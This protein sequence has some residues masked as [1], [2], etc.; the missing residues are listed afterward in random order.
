D[1]EL[2]GAIPSELGNLNNLREL[3]L[4]GN[5]LSGCVPA[6]WRSVEN[7]DLDSLGLPFCGASSATAAAATTDREALISLY[8]AT[9]G[10]N[11]KNNANWLSDAPVNTWFGVT[12]DD[13]GRVIALD[14]PKNGLRGTLPPELG[15]LTNLKWLY[16][17]EN[18]LSGTIPSELGRLAGLEWMGLWDNELS[19]S[20]PPALGQLTNLTDLSLVENQLSGPIP[21]ALGQ[22]TNLEWL[23][24]GG[25]QLSGS[26]PPALGQLTNLKWLYLHENDLSGTIPSA[27]G[28]LTDLEI[29]GL[30]GNELR[31][32]IPS[33]LGNLANLTELSLSE[34]Q[35]RGS[36]P[37]E[38]GNLTNLTELYLWG[39]ELRGSI[40][41]ELRNLT[42][43]TELHLSDNELSGCVPAVW[44]NVAIN[45]LD[46]LGLPFCR[47]A[48]DRAALIALYQ[49]ANGGN[50]KNNA[51]WLSDA[52]LDTWHGVTT[53]ENG[54]VIGLDL[55]FNGLSG[56]IPS[57]LGNL[58]NLTRLVLSVNRLRGP[59][60]AALGNLTNLTELGLSNNRLSGDIPPEL[61]QLTNLTRLAL[62]INRLRGSIPAELGNLANLGRLY[63]AGNG[64]S[65]CVPGELWRNVRSNDLKRLGLPVCAAPS[66]T[67]T[68]TP[69]SLA[70]DQVFAK[71]SPA[72]AFMETATGAAAAVLVEGGYLVTNAHAVWPYDAARVV[73]PD[74]TEFEQV[75]VKGWDLLADLA[76]LGPIDASVE[77]V[78]L[79]DGE[80]IPL[81]SEVYLVGYPGQAEAIPQPAIARGVL[82]RLREW[83]PVGITY[84]QTD[85][86][87][88]GGRSGGALVSDT[89]GVIGVSSFRIAGGEFELA[90]SSADILPRVRQLIAGED[91]AGLGERRLPAAGGGLRHELTLRNLWD[92]LGYLIN[93][94]AGAEIELDLI[95]KNDGGISVFDAAGHELLVLDDQRTGAETGSLVAQREGPRFLIAWQLDETA[96]DFTLTASHRLMPLNDPERGGQLQVG[97]TVRGN[98]DFP[99]DIDHFLLHLEE[100]E[101]VE[102]VARSALADTLLTVDYLGAVEEQVVRDDDSGG[103][104]FGLD[105]RIIYR[106]PHTGS[107][108]VVV[109]DVSRAAPGGYTVSVNPADPGDASPQSAPSG[110]GLAQ[111]RSTF[112]G[113]PASY[114]EIDPALMEIS[115]EDMFDISADA[116]PDH[117]DLVG[118]L[119]SDESH[120]IIAAS[121]QLT[122]AERIAAFDRELSEMEQDLLAG[123]AADI[124]EGSDPQSF[125]LLEIPPVG[126]RSLGLSLEFIEDG[127]AIQMEMLF[128]RRGNLLASVVTVSFAPH[129]AQE[130]VSAEQAARALDAQ[131]GR[132]LSTEQAR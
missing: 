97:Q 88:T 79:L 96:A 16:L 2:S 80:K 19:G 76:V 18:N 64:L 48:T 10:A 98:M 94:P 61:G 78:A 14:L 70:S 128:F 124:W 93:E 52:P 59:I 62:S 99:A 50:W 106:A 81:A 104:L 11:W 45:D 112:T 34:N 22:L 117:P 87:I 51:N 109:S 92:E 6:V 58:T 46:S 17:H 30:W 55:R 7:N 29:L 56:S 120:L 39:N 25:N 71:V 132:Y 9:D 86:A 123:S 53:D 75:A 43:L 91:P 42:N 60:P 77:P 125:G 32:S 103:G 24:L 36:I 100:N 118:F 84:F 72:I 23:D 122:G 102:I 49:A 82:S 83:E 28:Q 1:N 13:S 35:L 113:L 101:T 107:Y 67:S 85:A 114:T 115:P 54:R 116:Q 119:T 105:A 65:G 20:I 57:Q 110:F 3:W 40:P 95:G 66:A 111:L 33:E 15:Q 27:L 127:A 63:L 41:L 121:G 126:D 73:F 31:G 12:T 68:A 108:F 74:G 130:H 4:S 129:D 69:E 131:M 44:R 47:A 37:S 8:R 38:L 21:P 5:E 89:G 90:A 26:I